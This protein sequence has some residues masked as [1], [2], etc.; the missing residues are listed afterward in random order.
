M[1]KWH[2]RELQFMIRDLENMVLSI[3]CS[4]VSEASCVFQIQ[5]LKEAIV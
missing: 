2:F 5:V 4:I 1:R 3:E